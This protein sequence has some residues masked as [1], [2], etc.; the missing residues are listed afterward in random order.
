MILCWKQLDVLSTLSVLFLLGRL[1]D[2]FEIAAENRL[3]SVIA[4]E[5]LQNRTER[6]IVVRVSGYS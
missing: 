3:L 5:R 6:T 4:D 1:E 2:C